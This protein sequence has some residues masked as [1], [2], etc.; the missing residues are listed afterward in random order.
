[1]TNKT[2]KP[3]I[4]ILMNSFWV[5]K[6]GMSGGDMRMIQVFERIY[7]SFEKIDIYTSPAAKKM[8]GRRI[9]NANFILSDAKYDQGSLRKAY[10]QRSN[11]AKEKIVKKKY[12]ILYASSDFFTDVEPCNLYKKMYPETKWV[13]CIF[14][15]YPDWRKRPGS[16]IVNLV[17]SIIQN[18]SFRKIRKRADT[19]ININTQVTDYLV[20]KKRFDRDKIVLNPCGADLEYFKNLK[21]SRKKKNQVVF[22][23]RL[24][25]SKG[26]FDLVEIWKFVVKKIPNAK[27]III[28]GGSDEIK[29][30]LLTQIAKA[31]LEKNIELAGFLPDDETFKMIKSS[32]VFVLPSHE[33]GFGMVIAEAMACGIPA[34]AWNLKVYEEVF[35]KGLVTVIENDCQVFAKEIIRLL[36]NKKHYKKITNEAKEMVRSYG[37]GEIAS[38]EKEIIL[39]YSHEYVKKD[40]CMIACGDHIKQ[41]AERYLDKDILDIGCG[42]G[43]YTRLFKNNN[44]IGL[45]IQDLRYRKSIDKFKFKKYSGRKLPFKTSSFDVVVSFDVIEHVKNEEEFLYEINRVLKPNGLVH[46]A[47]PNRNRLANVLSAIIGRPVTYP[48][49]LKGKG[50]L[51]DRLGDVVHLREYT[52]KKLKKMF[53]ESRFHDVRV[54]NYWFGLRGRIN[55][56]IKRPIIK[57]MSQYIFVEARK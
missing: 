24:K 55:L 11:W 21:V 8:I 28:G 34:V 16:K 14:H 10:L 7:K 4:A 36:K 42:N 57:R 15:V 23:G 53:E 27:L 46:L 22:L 49:V 5:S 33:E 38:I 26:V 39:T 2:K 3:K 18:R 13:Q 19:V 35:P 9:K 25:P 30:E 1:M 20:D 54:V 43:D 37:L 45:D 12:D 56:G 41:I 17:G 48:L 32:Q 44:I 51:G 40:R 52:S 29:R 50:R 47:T 31:N 6:E